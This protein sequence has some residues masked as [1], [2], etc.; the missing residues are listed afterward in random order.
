MF[1]SGGNQDGGGGGTVLCFLR[2]CTCKL[3]DCYS[4]LFSPLRFSLKRALERMCGTLTNRCYSWCSIKNN[5]NVHRLK[6][7]KSL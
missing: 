6:L 3:L 5:T 4:L 1:T 2:T 7:V